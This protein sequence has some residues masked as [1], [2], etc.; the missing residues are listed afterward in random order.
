MGAPGVGGGLYEARV[1]LKASLM[2]ISDARRNYVG[3]SK[4]Y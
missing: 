1:V 4:K 2:Q 3:L